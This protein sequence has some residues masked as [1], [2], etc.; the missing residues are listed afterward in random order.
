MSQGKST[1]KRLLPLV[2]VGL[3]LLP[4]TPRAAAPADRRLLVLDALKQ[5]LGRSREKLKLS[6]E[7][8][9]YFLRYLVREYDDYDMSARF[10]AL[11]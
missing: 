9:P 10:G 4:G 7:D 2:L 1:M 8:P 11:L 3:V 6:G 5:E